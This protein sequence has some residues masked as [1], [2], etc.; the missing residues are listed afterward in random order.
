MSQLCET[1][2]RT[3]YA[4]CG[5]FVFVVAILVGHVVVNNNRA[6][7]AEQSIA[8]DV[9]TIK[10]LTQKENAEMMEKSTMRMND[11]FQEIRQRLSRIE[12][13]L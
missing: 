6:I 7:A 8:K 5:F 1:H 3:F 10:L 2:Q 13:K 12:A 4:V 11:G 9:S